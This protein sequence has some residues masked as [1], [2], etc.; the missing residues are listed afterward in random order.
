[1]PAGLPSGDCTTIPVAALLPMREAASPKYSRASTETGLLGLLCVPVVLLAEVLFEKFPPGSTLSAFAGVSSPF[2]AF[3]APA[4]GVNDLSRSMFMPACGSRPR[5]R[6]GS[7][8]DEGCSSGEG[9]VSS[10]RGL[11]VNF[12][13]FDCIASVG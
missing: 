3:D 10:S 6:F 11:E 12:M 7:L 1:M 13:P 5:C 4:L 2:E 8:F 9:G